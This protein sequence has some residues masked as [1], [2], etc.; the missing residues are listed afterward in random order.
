MG[1]KAIKDHYRIKHLVAIHEGKGICIGS[2]YVHDLIRINPEA[3]KIEW[4]N[5]GPSYNDELA[6]YWSEIHEDIDAFWALV[7]AP[8]TFS[9]NLPVYTYEGGK[10]VEYQCEEYGWPNVTHD[11]QMMYENTFFER[12]EDARKAG[13]RNAQAGVE[14]LTEIVERTEKDL[15]QR[16]EWL[17]ERKANLAELQSSS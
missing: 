17:A 1:W 10:V 16:R 13:I 11:G 7:D 3:R 2:S 14:S 9:R 5:L 8:D 15:A 12:P 4:G 6:R